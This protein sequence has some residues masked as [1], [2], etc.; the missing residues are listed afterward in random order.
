MNVIICSISIK[1][2]K[3]KANIIIVSQKLNA[4]FRCKSTAVINSVFSDKCIFIIS[5]QGD[6]LLQVAPACRR[7]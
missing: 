3:Y 7:Q 6:C 5:G 2:L 1:R 4:G